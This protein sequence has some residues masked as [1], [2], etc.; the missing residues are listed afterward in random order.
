MNMGS[1]Q[2][3]PR[4]MLSPTIRSP[5]T[6]QTS[7]LSSASLATIETTSKAAQESPNLYQECSRRM[8]NSNGAPKHKRPSTKS[9][10]S[11]PVTRFSS[12][13]IL[14]S[15]SSSKLMLVPKALEQS[16][17]KQTKKDANS[18]LPIAAAALLPQ[19]RNMEP[20]S[21]KS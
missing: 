20:L 19:N 16:L 6:K 4:S 10:E 11:S 3:L 21:W 8:S 12:D 17:S 14:T 5:R 1:N 15:H 18:L 2:P 13:Q 9:K 7:D